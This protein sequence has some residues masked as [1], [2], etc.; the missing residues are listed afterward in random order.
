MRIVSQM[1]LQT[2]FPIVEFNKYQLVRTITNKISSNHRRVCYRNKTIRRSRI[3]PKTENFARTGT[4]C[5]I[6]LTSEALRPFLATVGDASILRLC[7]RH[8][9][10]S[11]MQ[12]C[13][14]VQRH[15]ETTDV[16]VLREKKCSDR[17]KLETCLRETCL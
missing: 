5:E 9:R 11:V 13:G 6:F 12:A 14:R 7:N 3:D 10:R 17:L 8:D 2:K 16:R 4:W 1:M 15:E